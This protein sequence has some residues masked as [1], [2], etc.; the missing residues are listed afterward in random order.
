MQTGS[1]KMIASNAQNHNS[2][3]ANIRRMNAANAKNNMMGGMKTMG[4]ADN[5]LIYV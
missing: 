2:M 5:D 3:E 1:G 4:E